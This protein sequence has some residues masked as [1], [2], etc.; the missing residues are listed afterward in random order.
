MSRRNERAGGQARSAKL[1]EICKGLLSSSLFFLPFPF[2]HFLLFSP[3]LIVRERKRED[4]RKYP[5][6]TR[7]PGAAGREALRNQNERIGRRRRWLKTDDGEKGLKKGRQPRWINTI[8]CRD[9]RSV[10]YGGR[11][12]WRRKGPLGARA[13]TAVTI[14]QAVVVVRLLRRRYVHTRYDRA[15]R[16]SASLLGPHG[17]RW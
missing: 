13:Y 7:V 9:K 3:F 8:V 11:R 2:L 16:F 4:E 10:F 6:A 17:S 5:R 14:V 12:G 1:N 15:L